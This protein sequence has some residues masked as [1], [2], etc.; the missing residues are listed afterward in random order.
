MKHSFLSLTIA[1]PAYNEE[2][3]I[4]RVIERAMNAGRSL[5]SDYE[6]LVV[7]DGSTDGT[8]KIARQFAKKNARITIIRHRHNLGFS[9]AIKSCYS[10]ASKE[11]IFLL[12]GDGQIDAQDIAIFLRKAKDA[13]VVVG[14]R[15]SNPEPLTRRITSYVFHTLFRVL[16][17]VPLKEISTSILW[18]KSVLD[19]I[20]ITAEGRS[21]LIEPEVVYKAW[22]SG[23]R[24]SQVPIPYYPRVTGKPKGTNILMILMTLKELLRLWWT[25]RIQKNQPRNSS[26]MK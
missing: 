15:I 17:G 1:I 7:D 3:S 18:H 11:L 8:E 22:E 10:H 20:T 13:D 26:R 4:G 25:L 16:F 21:A 24:F 12:P 5:A 9:G 19:R 2:G 14:Y 23:F 6:I